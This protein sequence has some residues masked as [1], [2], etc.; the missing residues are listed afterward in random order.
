MNPPLIK[1]SDAAK[2]REQYLNT[3]KVQASNDQLNMNANMLYRTT[4]QLPVQPTDY[5][6]TTEKAADVDG[7][8]RE[9]RSFFASSGITNGTEAN[10]LAQR[11]PPDG[12]LFVIRYKTFIQSDIK[13]RGL[14]ADVVYVYLDKLFAKITDTQGVEFGVQ[15]KL[16]KNMQL[17]IQQI[18][19][20]M[21]NASQLERLEQILAQIPRGR[22]V[23][24]VESIIQE[25]RELRSMLPSETD[26]SR[27]SK[28]DESDR[29]SAGEA[30]S[31]AMSE[32]PT[33]DQ[34]QQ[35]TQQ[36]E[37][38]IQ[39]GT[40]EQ[41]AQLAEEVRQTFQLS[42]HATDLLQEVASFSPIRVSESS[43]S[44][45]QM[46]ISSI[47][48]PSY[49]TADDKSPPKEV[50]AKIA[51]PPPQNKRKEKESTRSTGKQPNKSKPI[52][53]VSPAK[54]S[55]PP[56]AVSS[57]VKSN[58]VTVAAPSAVA[59]PSTPVVGNL[60]S[61]SPS[62]IYYNPPR[63]TEI[64]RNLESHLESVAEE[65]DDSTSQESR[66]R[67]MSID[68]KRT[69]LNQKFEQGYKL[70]SNGRTYDSSASIAQA[71][72]QT[73][74]ALFNS[75]M[76]QSKT[77]GHGFRLQGRGLRAHAKN[78]REKIEHRIE[79]VFVK[80]KPYKQLGRYLINRDKLSDNIVMI[81]RPGGAPALPTEKVSHELGDV[82]RALVR[83]EMPKMD[84]LSDGDIRK[85]NEVVRYCRCTH[86]TVPSPQSK[87][88]EQKE[89]DRFNILRGEIQAGNDNKELVKEFKLML[90][91]FMNAGRIPRRQAQE[92]LTDIAAMGL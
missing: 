85:L 67:T 86:I 44:Q 71:K 34:T 31:D 10:E 47:E 68:E 55:K 87:T 90:V 6:T 7:L 5:R 26:F 23:P 40:R 61:Q 82:L 20:N 19:N 11:L 29:A 46:S 64:S 50:A 36:L 77:Q 63:P 14:P 9:V 69:F 49:I 72:Y 13:G 30:L 21:V 16:A 24:N 28:M 22:D 74:N 3:L 43:P 15:Q 54:A 60:P 70:K 57:T 56:P 91:R 12:L 48:T 80:P 62:M 51:S 58:K 66:W 27:I 38:S 59:E 79:G 8:R 52:A 53:P 73:L 39:S 1:P 2:Y 33:N 84:K 37:M 18:A 81:K 75:Y 42:P 35:L 32:L 41:T 45:N 65:P 89:L 92:I 25:V 17:S 76:Q 83:D 88:D 78:N 4:Q